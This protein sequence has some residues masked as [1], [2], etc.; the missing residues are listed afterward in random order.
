MD[1]NRCLPRFWLVD[2]LKRKEV[3]STR[4]DKSVG[5]TTRRW[6]QVNAQ[7]INEPSNGNDES[8]QSMAEAKNFLIGKITGLTKRRQTFT[9]LT[10]QYR[11]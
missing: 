6:T 7:Q 11:H 5:N 3:Y 9:C 10:A 2:S 1:A 4:L 8:M